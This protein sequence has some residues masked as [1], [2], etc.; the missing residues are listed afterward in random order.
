MTEYSERAA[1][2]KGYFLTVTMQGSRT[3]S[4]FMNGRKLL[5][6]PTGGRREGWWERG[7]EWGGRERETERERE[8]ERED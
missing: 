5:G 7:G 4:Y 6:S 1:M 8:G 2:H 3:L